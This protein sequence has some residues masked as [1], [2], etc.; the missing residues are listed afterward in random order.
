MPL[1]MCQCAG[2]VAGSIDSLASGLNTTAPGRICCV[3]NEFLRYLTVLY[4]SGFY[5]V[6]L[7]SQWSGVVRRRRVGKICL[8]RVGA[9]KHEWTYKPQT[10]QRE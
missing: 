9:F 2:S 1:E 4:M 7:L 10:T 5:S 8:V 6:C 3:Y